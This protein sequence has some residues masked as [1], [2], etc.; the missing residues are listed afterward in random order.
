MDRHAK[1]CP[2]LVSF[3]FETLGTDSL[4]TAQKAGK[5]RHA[6]I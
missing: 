5:S 1:T 6:G 3:R 4:P 2:L